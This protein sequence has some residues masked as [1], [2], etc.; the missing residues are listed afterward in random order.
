MWDNIGSMTLVNREQEGWTERYCEATWSGKKEYIN[1]HRDGHWKKTIQQPGTNRKSKK[2]GGTEM[3]NLEDVKGKLTEVRSKRSSMGE[4]TKKH[5]PNLAQIYPLENRECKP[6][7][8]QYGKRKYKESNFKMK[9]QHTK[10]P[11]AEINEYRERPLNM[12][13]LAHMYTC[14]H[15]HTHTHTNIRVSSKESPAVHGN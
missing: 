9:V 3:M 10:R 11:V 1:I 5:L 4:E 12:H 8:K 2:G 15:T 6:Q 13:V 7:W 14:T